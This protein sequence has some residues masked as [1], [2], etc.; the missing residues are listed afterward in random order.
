MD[1]ERPIEEARTPPAHW[2]TDPVVL[3]REREQVFRRAW[4]VVAR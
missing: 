4:Q 1:P 3:Q 2:Y